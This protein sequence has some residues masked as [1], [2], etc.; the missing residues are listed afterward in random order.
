M[1]S[2]HA[3]VRH[4]G[5]VPPNAAVDIAG[6][7]A[8]ALFAGIPDDQLE[9]MAHLV[10]SATV[11]AATVLVS[12]QLPGDAVY[13]IISGSVKRQLVTDDGAEITLA[14]LGPGDTIGE[15]TL[16]SRRAHATSVVTRQET[17][18]MWIDRKE[19]LR[20]LDL[21]P[22]LSRNLV[23]LLSERLRR[24]DERIATLSTLD[25]TGRVAHQLLRLAERFGRTQPGVGVHISMPV[26]QGEIAEMVAATRERV[27]QVMMGLR[28]AGVLTIDAD[29][30]M[31]VHRPELLIELSR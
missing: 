24:A 22:A 27:N 25:V 28:K 11:P 3:A 18:I 26:T 2:P 30:R 19:F 1:T 9:P 14:L 21:A 23:R 17:T 8:L 20:C 15:S 29:H 10:H 5:R 4:G 13:F 31:T 7:K 12:A 6:I 16:V